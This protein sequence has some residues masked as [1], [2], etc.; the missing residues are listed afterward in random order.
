MISQVDLKSITFRIFN[1]IHYQLSSLLIHFVNPVHF[2]LLL[3]A[4]ATHGAVPYFV[5]QQLYQEAY[6]KWEAILVNR[7]VA[8]LLLSSR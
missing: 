6:L 4:V 8:A 1:Y 7:R 5:E 2:S 3:T